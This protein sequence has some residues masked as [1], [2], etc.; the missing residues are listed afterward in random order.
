MPSF[1]Y[2]QNDKLM[3][4]KIKIAITNFNEIKKIIKEENDCSSNLIEKMMISVYD[5]LFLW[6]GDS[7]IGFP[8]NVNINLAYQSFFTEFYSFLIF[9]SKCKNKELEKITDKVLY[10]GTICRYLGRAKENNNLYIVPIFDERWSSWSKGREN[11]YIKKHFVGKTTK[12]ICNTRASFGIDLTSLG[13]SI[14]G[15]K[16]VVYPMIKSD[17]DEISFCNNG[18]IDT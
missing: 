2:L 17:V 6:V 7:A 4:K 3:E 5:V 8:K 1:S 12:V 14:N 10:K 13:F 11:S 18:I 16:E 9:A 15:E